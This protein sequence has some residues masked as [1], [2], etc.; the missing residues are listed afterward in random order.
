M[1][2][3]SLSSITKLLENLEKKNFD[4]RFPE[5]PADSNQQILNTGLN[6]IITEL[7][8]GYIYKAFI[9]QTKDVVSKLDMDGNYLFASESASSLLGF[10]PQELVGTSAYSYIHEDDLARIKST[11]KDVFFDG[12]NVQSIE[13]RFKTKN[14]NYVWVESRGLV[15]K[16]ADKDQILRLTRDISKRKEIEQLLTESNQKIKKI[17]EVSP[18][19]MAM[20]SMDG[21]WLDVNNSLLN[22]LGY[23]KE[24]LLQK[25]FQEITYSEDLDKDLLLAQ[26]L[27]DNRTSYTVEKRYI[28]KDGE[29]VWTILSVV[30]V[31]SEEDKPL[32][33]LA[34]IEDITETKFKIHELQ[35]REQE[36]TRFKKA[37]DYSFNHIIITDIDGVIL[38]ANKAAEKMTG[39]TFAEMK[40]NTPRLWGRQMPKVFYDKMWE[41]IKIEK[42]PFH[43]EVKNKRKNG[44][45]YTAL[46]SISPILDDF[47]EII[48]F[49]GIEEDITKIKELDK[50]KSEFLSIAAHQLRSPL[51]SMRWHMDLLN[52]GSLGELSDKA[53]ESVKICLE[54]N[55][56]LLKLVNDLLDI[57]RIEERRVVDNPQN[58]DIKL[59]M[60]TIFQNNKP[61]LANKK[62]TL[63]VDISQTLPI[64]VIDKERLT[65]VLE[66]LINNATKYNKVGGNINV[67][68]TS[69]SEF[70]NIQ[71]ADTGIGIP[72]EALS[73]ITAK[74]YR[75]ENALKSEIRGSGL[76]LYVVKA[77]TESW[78][79]N[80]FIT[81]E[82]NVGSTITL[83]IPLKPINNVLD[84]NLKTN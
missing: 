65:E 44:E 75:A 21:M 3:T 80:I 63:N 73:K 46:A 33:F 61:E 77:Y 23:S 25:N 81:S 2:D 57:T 67:S 79:G 40:Q 69:E 71:I 8:D 83:K 45:L 49:L 59:I 56:H 22:I 39:Y 1:E 4:F 52:D 35:K 31:K 48:G 78:G 5:E 68:V 58:T 16:T 60:E 72:I 18:I 32:Y 38:F 34:Q 41:T 28:R 15:L 26:K 64:I 84:T 19:G 10:T 51:G 30:I 74:F 12:D 27:K 11:H 7:G 17:F 54:T 24:E 42:K 76:G 6:R 62:I 13:Y 53:K 50:M 70:I 9:G 36:L 66:N 29:I 43:G 82:E 55:I 37:V 20:V 47:N 14:G